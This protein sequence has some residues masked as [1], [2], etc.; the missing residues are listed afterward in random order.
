LKS[1]YRALAL[2]ALV[3]PCFVDVIYDA[4]PL[5]RA[6]DAAVMFAAAAEAAATIVTD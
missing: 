1:T 3:L 4:Q 6:D 2:L 5:M